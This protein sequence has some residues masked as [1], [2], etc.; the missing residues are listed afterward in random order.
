VGLTQFLPLLR[1]Y[2][3]AE[4]VEIKKVAKRLVGR[5]R[6]LQNK[7]KGSLRFEAKR[8][9]TYKKIIQL[10]GEKRCMYIFKFFF[11]FIWNM[12]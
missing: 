8:C 9:E 5:G 1:L 6:G 12:L 2:S 4:N 11:A 10:R 3:V 7:A